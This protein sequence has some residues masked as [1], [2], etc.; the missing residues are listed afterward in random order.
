MCSWRICQTEEILLSDAVLS[1]GLDQSCLAWHVD[2]ESFVVIVNILASNASVQVVPKHAP[3]QAGIIQIETS[4]QLLSR[5]A[6]TRLVNPA[7]SLTIKE[8]RSRYSQNDYKRALLDKVC[9]LS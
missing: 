9:A 2:Q 6:S 8:S 5:G 3:T 1:R 7:E 4:S